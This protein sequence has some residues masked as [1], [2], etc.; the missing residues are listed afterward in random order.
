MT[1]LLRGAIIVFALIIG[2][3]PVTPIAFGQD[4]ASDARDDARDASREF[5]DIRRER[6]R[7]AEI[8]RSKELF[9]AKEKARLLCLKQINEEEK[10]QGQ[11]GVDACLLESQL[12]ELLSPS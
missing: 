5:A 8:K 11:T 10:M 4:E 12:A 2:F 1:H 3:A 7:L 9:D 6:L